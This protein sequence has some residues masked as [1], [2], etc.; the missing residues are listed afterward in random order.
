MHVRWLSCGLVAVLGVV[1]C[2]DSSGGESPDWTNGNVNAGTGGTTGGRAPTTPAASGGLWGGGTIGSGVATGTQG[3]GSAVGGG[4]VPGGAFGGGGVPGADIPGGGTPGGGATAGGTSG[5]PCDVA[6]ILKEKCQTCHG[7]PLMSGPMPLVTW[8]D[9]QAMMPNG[10]VA[11]RVRARINDTANPM[12]PPARPPLTAAEKT[13]LQTYLSGGAMRST[14]ACTP[15]GPITGGTAGGTG[16]GGADGYKPADSECDYIQEFRAHGGQTPGDTSPFTA[17]QGGDN[18][19]M[20]YFKPKWTEKVHVIRIDP[21]TDNG[22]VLHHWLLYME[23]GVGSGDGTHQPDI[24]LQSPTAQLLSGWAPGNEGLPLARDVGL[25]TVSA[26]NARL[27]IEI[28]YNTNSNPANRADRS[29]ARLC[30]TKTLRPKAAS[31]HWLGTQAIISIGLPSEAYGSCTVQQQSH[32]IAHSPHMHTM[33]R[34]MKTIITKKGG[35][36][37]TITDQP[38]A[39]DDQQIFPIKNAAGEIVVEPGDVIDTTCSYEAGIF[40]FGPNTD[41]EMCYNF[42]LAWPPGSLS[43]GI[44]GIVGGLNTCMDTLL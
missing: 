27:G 6:A 37:V 24:G 9:L 21:I 42:I 18:Y 23:D 17:P 39:F 5:L 13:T 1:A 19:E 40:T 4:T 32:I 3:G 12:P 10:K 43:N 30:V 33:G 20:F 26:P 16:G 22:K 31:V 29:G 28:H 7:N 34:Y 11:D 2:G 44:P 41:Q 15:T 38:F 35:Q 8:N 25:V 36:K 14:A